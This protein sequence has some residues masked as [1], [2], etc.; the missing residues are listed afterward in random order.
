MTAR[1]HPLRC[2]SHFFSLPFSSL[3]STALFFKLSFIE[4]PS[5]AFPSTWSLLCITSS[6]S[7]ADLLYTKGFPGY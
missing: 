7:S 4:L 3:G 6:A 2:G 1:S 5:P